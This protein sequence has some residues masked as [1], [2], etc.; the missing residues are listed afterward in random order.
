[1]GDT[2]QPQVSSQLREGK[3]VEGIW[4]ESGRVDSSSD[5]EIQSQPVKLPRQAVQLANRVFLFSLS[6]SFSPLPLQSP[7]LHILC[8]LLVNFARFTRLLRP[9]QKA[10]ER[11]LFAPGQA[12]LNRV[13]DLCCCWTFSS[14][15]MCFSIQ[16][17]CLQDPSSLGRE[18]HPDSKEI[19]SISI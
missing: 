14:V 2:L 4:A 12:R 16:I 7:L 6:S 1:M 5:S 18:I 9:V 13:C 11:A 19:I 17:S 10:A 3:G 8:L 15:L